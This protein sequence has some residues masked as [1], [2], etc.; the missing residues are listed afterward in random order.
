MLNSKL[1]LSVE[2]RDEATKQIAQGKKVESESFFNEVLE[3]R[4]SELFR[5]TYPDAAQDQQFGDF[6]FSIGYFNYDVQKVRV[7]YKIRFQGISNF[8]LLSVET[9]DPEILHY[10][11]LIHGNSEVESDDPNPKP[12]I[13]L[14]KK[15]YLEKH[16][17]DLASVSAENFLITYLRH[18]SDEKDYLTGPF[19]ID[20]KDRPPMPYFMPRPPGSYNHP[21]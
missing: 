8:R 12:D 1:S 5:Q 9:E 13:E 4:L 20:K 2:P 3:N 6:S 11:N 19:Y 10:F 18:W 15:M 16:G 21:I 17:I 7:T 14:I